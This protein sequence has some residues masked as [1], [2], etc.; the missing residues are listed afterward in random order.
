MLFV[1]LDTTAVNCL[2][3][4]ANP[5]HSSV[6]FD[7]TKETLD[8]THMQYDTDKTNNTSWARIGYF[9]TGV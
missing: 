3:N 5:T 7:S 8:Y 6:Q 9:C 4:A 2:P 1:D